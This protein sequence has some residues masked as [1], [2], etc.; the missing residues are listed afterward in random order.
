M[1]DLKGQ[2]EEALAASE[3]E[4]KAKMPPLLDNLK[5]NIEGLL[6][7]MPDLIPRLMGKLGEIDVAKFVSEDPALSE[8][9][10]D[11][12]WEGAGIVSKNESV[13][14]KLESAG[15]IS[16]NFEATDSPMKGYLKIEGG[17]LIGGVT[18]L[19]QSDIQISAA[20]AVLVDLLIG[21]IDPVKGFMTRKYQ[22]KGNM[23]KGMKLA[24]VMTALAK[25]LIGKSP[26]G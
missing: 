19:A 8:R 22:M 7:S 12:L 5:G 16:V 9:F 26:L 15:D 10:M 11:V 23:S 1:A 3:E 14:K 20:T 21:K 17:G 4:L 24:P 6:D 2:V 25:E 18:P 13:K